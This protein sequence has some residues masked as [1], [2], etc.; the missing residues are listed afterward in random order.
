MYIEGFFCIFVV[1]VDIVKNI[2]DDIN[3][4]LRSVKIMSFDNVLINV[5]DFEFEKV[6]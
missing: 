6:L 1:D 5:N 2:E 4:L 3:Q